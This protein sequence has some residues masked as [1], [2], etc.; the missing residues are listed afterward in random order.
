MDSEVITVDHTHPPAASTGNVLER[1]A[2][3]L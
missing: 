1:L 3:F 2:E